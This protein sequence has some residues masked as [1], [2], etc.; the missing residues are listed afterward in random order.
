[1]DTLELLRRKAQLNIPEHSFIG[2][3]EHVT[4]PQV[5]N[6]VLA[7]RHPVGHS[8]FSRSSKAPD[9]LSVGPF[10]GLVLFS[11]HDLNDFMG[12]SCSMKFTD[13]VSAFYG[14]NHSETVRRNISPHESLIGLGLVLDTG[15]RIQ[16]SALH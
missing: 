1:M 14:A 16:T 11:N 4:E 3:R 10:P 8:S 6:S 5:V 15:K 13:D 7:D 9:G 12:S 2:I